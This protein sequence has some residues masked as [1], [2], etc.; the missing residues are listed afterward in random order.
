M[1]S[2]EIF[3]LRKE[4]KNL[5]NKLSCEIYEEP[6]RSKVMDTFAKSIETFK[7]NQADEWAIRAFVYVMNDVSKIFIKESNYKEIGKCINTLGSIHLDDNLLLDEVLM[8]TIDKIKSYKNAINIVIEEVNLYRKN[9][10]IFKAYERSKMLNIN[11]DT[12]KEIIPYY[13]YPITDLC[14]YYYEKNNMEEFEKYYNELSSL[15]LD[16]EDEFL[17]NRLLKV[18]KLADKTRADKLKAG[19]LYKE[20]KYK[21]ALDIYSKIIDENSDDIKVNQLMGWCIFHIVK[22]GLE[23]KEDIKKLKR[24]LFKYFDLNIEKPSI[25]HS[26]ILKLAVDIE[27]IQIN[28]FLELWNIDFLRDEDYK[29]R[30]IEEYRVYK[31]SLFESVIKKALKCHIDDR[32]ILEKYLVHINKAIDLS[33]SDVSIHRIKGN[34]MLQLERFDEAEKE[35]LYVLKNK[36]S[37]YWA[38]Q[39]LAEY[40]FMKNDIDSSIACYCKALSLINKNNMEFSLTIRN[41]FLKILLSLNLYSEAKCELE[42]ILKIRKEKNYSIDDKLLNMVESSWYKEC[43]SKKNNNDFYDKYIGF[44]E[45][46]L[47]KDMKKVLAVLGNLFEKKPKKL[48]YNLYIKDKINDKGLRILDI[49]KDFIKL[50]NIEEGMPLY[51]YAEYNSYQKKEIIYRIEHRADGKHNDLLENKI[52]VINFVD[53]KN[54]RAYVVVDKLVKNLL[55]IDNKDNKYKIGN[56]VIVKG[57]NTASD[58]YKIIECN[59]APDDTVSEFKR[60]MFM[61]ITHVSAS[62]DG[63]D[64]LGNY[65]N[66][67]LMKKYNISLKDFVTCDSVLVYNKKHDNW[68]WSAFSILEVDKQEQ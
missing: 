1:D 51:V 30:Y 60:N 25:L 12:S 52:G 50:K 28:K 7:N 56:V 16:V 13:I 17:K 43:D 42:A 33:D 18:Y 34:L 10:E 63:F 47:T 58:K 32:N 36:V 38:W 66:N 24:Y 27:D 8:K 55:M 26:M 21:D 14:I 61:E 49:K 62:G 35:I 64:D 2:R 48:F 31:G 4:Y 6:I 65:I 41:D 15:K 57:V 45:K 37:E 67:S 19:E 22:E 53:T 68:G 29:Q 20:K 5:M 59:H 23:Q 3:T 9:G 11:S 54:S 46:I 39:P 44:A 40:Y